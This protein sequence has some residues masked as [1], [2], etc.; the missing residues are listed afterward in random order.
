MHFSEQTYRRGKFFK[1]FLQFW[2][3]KP[4]KIHR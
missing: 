4:K 1:V 3:T 2:Y